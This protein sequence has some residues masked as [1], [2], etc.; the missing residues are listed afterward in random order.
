MEIGTIIKK[1][2]NEKGM[3][4]EAAA[5]AL[6]VSRQTVSNWENGRSYPDIISVIKMSEIYSV[7]LDRL[8]KEE[9]SMSYREY[10]EESTNTVKSSK[11]RMITE[12]AIGLAGAW[13]MAMA[14]F[15]LTVGG[16]ELG[17]LLPTMNVLLAVIFFAAA[18][19]MG[20]QN[21]F[22]KWKWLAVPVFGLMYALIGYVSAAGTEDML[23]KT[24]VWPDLTKLPV[25]LILA[26]A[27]LW[28]GGYIKN[29][30]K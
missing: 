14:A 29:R 13:I 12:A 9:E 4:Q 19:W 25:A 8:L 28:L 26:A 7:S 30:K 24:V 2:R 15:W 6:G 1:I 18:L 5:E 23:I 16:L 17:F 27:G 3:T 10:L 21:L 11:R 20:Y 22:C